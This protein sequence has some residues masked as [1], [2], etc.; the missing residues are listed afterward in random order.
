MITRAYGILNQ[1]KMSLDSVE[2]DHTVS[3]AVGLVASC[4]GKVIVSGM[5]KAGIIGKKIAATLSSTGTP[6]LFLHPGEAQHGDLGVIGSG[7]LLICLSNSGKTREIIEMV[8]LSKEIG[9]HKIITI[10]SDKDSPLAKISDVIFLTGGIPEA[11]QFGLVPTSS[12][13]AM[14]AIGDVLS[15][16]TMEQKLFSIE[17]YGKIHHGGYI[18]KKARG[19]L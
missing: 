13:I 15:I 16:L 9:D 12:T 5:G 3:I 10:T 14:M 17:D 2:F 4:K 18:G 19:I 8:K 7:D 6:S 1:L 11:C